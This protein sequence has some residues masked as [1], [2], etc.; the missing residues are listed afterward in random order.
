MKR[1]VQWVV[2][3]SVTF[4]ILDLSLGY[5]K[6]W[7]MSRDG[8]G[9]N[10][11]F[12]DPVL[13]RNDNDIVVLGASIARNSI[14]AGRI[15]DTLGLKTLNAGENGQFFPFYLSMLKGMVGADREPKMIILCLYSKIMGAKGAGKVY[16]LLKPYYKMNIGDIDSCLEAQAAGHKFL[17][18]LNS[19]R[20]NDNWLRILSSNIIDHDTRDKYGFEGITSFAGYPWRKKMDSYAMPAERRNQLTEF[21]NI[22]EENGI[23][24]LILYTP[25]YA[26]Q[27]DT[28]SDDAI[29]ITRKIASER[30]VEFYDHTTLQPFTN[31]STLFHD[32]LHLNK[33]G[34]QMYTDTV[35]EL[36]RRVQGRN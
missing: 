24:L 6:R 30:G 20:L 36:I 15:Q 17:L 22:C 31:D 12:I 23:R 11:T 7:L 19:F 3:V 34:A 2:I 18:N 21:I 27:K 16:S 14:D 28:L 29:K 25:L 5:L 10:Y 9:G 26:N 35:I 8:F 4:L 1:F 13:R 33:H 32:W